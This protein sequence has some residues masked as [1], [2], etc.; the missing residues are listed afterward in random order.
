M[1]LGTYSDLSTSVF[2]RLNR[3]AVT[4]DYDTAIALAEAEVNRRLA[5]NPVRPMHTHSTATVSTEYIAQPT[6]MIDVDSLAIAGE[7]ILSTSAAN[8][9][10][11]PTKTAAKPQ[12]YAFVGSEIRLYPAPDTSYTLD[13][14]YWAKVPN[15][16][17]TDDT[18]WLLANHPDVYFHGVLA[19]LYQQYFDQEAADYQAGL[20][21][22]ALDKVL[23]SYP[24][25]TD[26]RPLRSDISPNQLSGW[27]SVL[28]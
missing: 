17:S 11:M 22:T 18:N 15:L 26:N 7:P 5:L 2:S 4:A 14:I 12:Y 8:I 25:Q 21:D 13:L 9:E 28:V 10:E 19:H 20:F 23:S 6:D 3:T 16:N 27:R 24:T 1:A